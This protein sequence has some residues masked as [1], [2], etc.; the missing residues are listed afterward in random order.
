MDLNIDAILKEMLSAVKNEAGAGWTKIKA[1][2]DEFLKRQKER[3]V[4]V[5]NLAISGDISKE[6]F[7]SILE[8]ESKLLESE[9]LVLQ[10][11]SKSAAQNAANA[12]LAILNKTVDKLIGGIA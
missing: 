2:A 9:L 4:M 11:I 3:Y 6:K 12:A 5:A 7:Q 1:T 10:V 8:D